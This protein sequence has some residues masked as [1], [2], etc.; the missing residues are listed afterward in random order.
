MTIAKTQWYRCS[1]TPI[2]WIREPSND[3]SAECRVSTSTKPR[4]Y[5]H[6]V[7]VYSECAQR[8]VSTVYPCHYTSCYC[9]QYRLAYPRP[10]LCHWSPSSLMVRIDF[11]QWKPCLLHGIPVQQTLSGA[12]MHLWMFMK[13]VV[14]LRQVGH[15][16]SNALTPLVRLQS[17]GNFD[18][19]M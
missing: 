13:C 3:T 5:C 11:S 15:L 1:S 14:G 8:K 10:C 7:D 6:V 16:C 17:P 19:Q 18:D 4:H 2:F 9:W 12:G